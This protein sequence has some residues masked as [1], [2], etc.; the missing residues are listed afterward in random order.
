MPGPCS[1]PWLPLVEPCPG[2]HFSSSEFQSSQSWCAEA[3]HPLRPSL[4]VLGGTTCSK[5]LLSLLQLSPS[6]PRGVVASN[7]RDLHIL[8]WPQAEPWQE[9]GVLFLTHSRPGGS[10]PGGKVAVPLPACSLF[11]LVL[12]QPKATVFFV[13]LSAVG[14]GRWYLICLLQAQNYFWST[15]ILNNEVMCVYL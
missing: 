15:I 9:R 14:L 4:P 5:R 10:L 11:L 1:C 12:E 2:K 13:H 6:C 3:C 8:A 7:L